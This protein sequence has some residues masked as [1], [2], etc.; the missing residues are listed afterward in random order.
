MISKS[1]QQSDLVQ[2]CNRIT[3]KVDIVSDSPIKI[4]YKLY[5]NL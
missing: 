2:S 3:A 1:Y 4:K 5:V